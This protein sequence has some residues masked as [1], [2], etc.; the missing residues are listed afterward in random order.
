[1]IDKAISTISRC[2]WRHPVVETGCLSRGRGEAC[3]PSIGLPIGLPLTL[4]VDRFAG[5]VQ[6]SKRLLV[7]SKSWH[8][9]VRNRVQACLLVAS[10]FNT[11][12]CHTVYAQIT[13]TDG[14]QCMMEKFWEKF[15]AVSMPC[16][17]T[18]WVVVLACDCRLLLAKCPSSALSWRVR[19]IIRL[20][21]GELARW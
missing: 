17:V 5:A 3:F 20:Q 6:P 2:I 14:L 1:M 4:N 12:H 15:H 19:Y 13:S 9:L 10:L 16:D 18:W 7:S 21:C 11:P 8:K